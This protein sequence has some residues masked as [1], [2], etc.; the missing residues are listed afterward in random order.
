MLPPLAGLI[1]PL[2][3]RAE[4][5]IA[6]PELLGGWVPGGPLLPVLL[7]V[8][9]RGLVPPTKHVLIERVGAFRAAA[10]AA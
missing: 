6:L 7:P 8:R 1:R 2:D 5:Y 9:Y 3:A 4:E 10:T